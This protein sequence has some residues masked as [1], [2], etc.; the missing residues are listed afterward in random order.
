MSI[1]SVKYHAGIVIEQL[2]INGHADTIAGIE[3]LL[4]DVDDEGQVDEA[5]HAIIGQC[6]VRALGDLQ[7]RSLPLTE[8]LKVLGR[9]ERACRRTLKDRGVAVDGGA[10]FPRA[11]PADGEPRRSADAGA[12]DGGLGN[13]IPALAQLRHH[14]AELG[15]GNLDEED[16]GE[17]AALRHFIAAGA[18][19]L[20]MMAAVVFILTV[21]RVPNLW[22]ISETAKVGGAG[23]VSD[24]RRG[25]PSPD[26]TVDHD[27]RVIL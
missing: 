21:Y 20:A 15:I 16:D 6:H 13:D 26:V 5:L 10:A 18:F 14:A 17:T 2:S 19:V 27:G 9:L 3:R 8:W 12:G 4:A 7:I 24:Y 1:D 11:P 25:L 23:D 22:D